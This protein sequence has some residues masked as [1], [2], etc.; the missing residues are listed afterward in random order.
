L[1]QAVHAAAGVPF[2]WADYQHL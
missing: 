1:L 2:G